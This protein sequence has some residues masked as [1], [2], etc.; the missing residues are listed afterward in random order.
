MIGVAEPQPVCSRWDDS[1]N[2]EG[3]MEFGAI[4]RAVSESAA[5]SDDGNEITGVVE[6]GVIVGDGDEI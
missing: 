5:I 4:A 2:R 1:L 6:F 3:Q